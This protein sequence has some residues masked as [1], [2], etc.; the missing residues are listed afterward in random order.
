MEL[1]ISSLFP[2]DGSLLR[3]PLPSTGFLGLV[4]PLHRYYWALRFPVA[5]D[6]LV[7][8]AR[9]VPSARLIR[10]PGARRRRPRNLG[11]G[12]RLPSRL[13]STE[14][15]GPPRFL[16]NPCQR[17]PFLDPGGSTCS[18]PL[19]HRSILPSDYDNFVGPTNWPFGARSRGPL[20]RC[21]RFAVRVASAPR[22]TRYWPAG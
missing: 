10:F 11:F 20:A 17:A 7:C 18:S 5:T 14:A 16:G 19:R 13:F 9:S 12:H 22:K 15:T 3:R 1:G 2:S 8:L 4:L 6:R 21:L